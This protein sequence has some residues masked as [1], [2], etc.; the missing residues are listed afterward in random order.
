MALRRHPRDA[1]CC[2]GPK[3]YSHVADSDCRMDEVRGDCTVVALLR[4]NS[5]LANAGQP[6][7]GYREQATARA[8]ALK[9][10]VHIIDD[11]H[12][13]LHTV[14]DE[15]EGNNHGTSATSADTTTKIT[16]GRPRLA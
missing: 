9:S 2:R 7:D 16:G 13:P 14:T 12:Q 8:E 1:P 10:I 6:A 15:K 3:L 4:L 11:L 5:V